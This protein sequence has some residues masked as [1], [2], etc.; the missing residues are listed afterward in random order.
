MGREGQSKRAVYQSKRGIHCKFNASEQSISE[1]GQ[2]FDE[3]DKILWRDYLSAA[4]SAINKF[5][6]GPIPPFTDK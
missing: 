3:I 1:L 4:L 2:P 6:H 5:S